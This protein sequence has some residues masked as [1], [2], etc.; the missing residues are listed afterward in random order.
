MAAQPI[1]L[2]FN[3][4]RLAGFTGNQ[5]KMIAFFLMLLDH[6]G[7]MLIENGV[8]YGQNPVYWTMALETQA[9]RRWYLLATVFRYLGRIAFPLFA[10]LTV[11]GCVHTRS[12]RRYIVRMA[13]FAALSEVPFDLACRGVIWYPEYQNTMWTLLL[14]IMAIAGMEK[15]KKLH[16]IFRL[17]IAGIFCAAAYLLKTDY[18]AVGVG[19]ISILYLFHR[20]R[21]IQLIAGAVVSAAESI[22][23]CGVSALAFGLIRFYNGKRGDL[24]LKYFF[25]F[26]YPLHLLLFWAM[27]YFANRG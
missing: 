3:K 17:M 16:M 4:R 15:A 13:V 2:Q 5:L 22:E 8:L 19:L 25:Y 6:I 7:Y 12:I 18:G 14:G 23:M 10:F 20:E 9:G 1:K 27:V 11:E 21:N 24:P 26:A